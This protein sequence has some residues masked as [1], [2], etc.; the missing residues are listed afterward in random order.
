MFSPDPQVLIF[1]LGPGL[2]CLHRELDGG[3]L[4]ALS[5]CLLHS[6]GWAW[7]RTTEPWRPFPQSPWC[8]KSSITGPFF[9]FCLFLCCV[10]GQQTGRAGDSTNES[11]MLNNKSYLFFLHF[12]CFVCGVHTCHSACMEVR[13]QLER[14]C[15][16]FLPRGSQGSN[17]GR[18]PCGQAP[19]PTAHLTNPQVY[20][21]TLG[22]I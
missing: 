13:G 2:S 7:P 18:Q 15:S 5:S 9:L 8:A 1:H 10:R 22:C 11:N 12:I 16:L 17:S 21:R 19:L 14:V 20:L 6:S 3:L 4:S